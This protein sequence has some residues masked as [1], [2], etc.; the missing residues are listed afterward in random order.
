MYDHYFPWVTIGE[1][2]LDAGFCVDGVEG[3]LDTLFLQGLFNDWESE[4]TGH[5]LLKIQGEKQ[6]SLA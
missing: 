6:G 4:D 2:N 3:R 1:E 5:F